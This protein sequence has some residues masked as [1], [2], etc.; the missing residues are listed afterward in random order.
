MLTLTTYVEDLVVGVNIDCRWSICSNEGD[1]L[2]VGCQFDCS[3]ARDCVAW[4]EDGAA[5]NGSEHGQIFK[6]H[7]TGAIF[8]NAD[9]TVGTYEVDVGL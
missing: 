7:L 1:T 8:T 2:G 3:F 4:I 5:W 6:S 9:S